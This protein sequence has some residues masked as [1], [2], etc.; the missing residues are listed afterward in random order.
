MNDFPIKVCA[1]ASGRHDQKRVADLVR[2]FPDK[3]SIPPKE[4]HYRRLFMANGSTKEAEFQQLLSALPDPVPLKEIL[5]GVKTNLVDHPAALLGE[6]GLDRSFRIAFQPLPAPPPRKLSPFSV[7]IDHQIAILE[8]QLDLAVELQRNVSLHSVGSQQV[9]MDLLKRM[10][11]KHGA[12]WRAIS[13]DL[14]SCGISLEGWKTIE[15]CAEDRLLVESDYDKIECSVSQTW[16]MI[17]VIASLREWEIETSWAEEEP[18]LE[19]WG[20]VRRL[21]RN[22]LRFQAGGHP[23]IVQKSRRLRKQHQYYPSDESEEE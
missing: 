16:K 17:E 5:D 13:I 20:V 22:W 4:E 8:A 21:K 9:T 3:D 15:G 18:P 6:V 14:H 7:P 10:H 23:E 19:N 1:M 12:R 11:E 2:R